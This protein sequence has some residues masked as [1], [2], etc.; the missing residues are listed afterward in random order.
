MI[1]ILEIC[2]FN[3]QS[4]L[5]AQA[6]GANR[7]EL[8]VDP[9]SGGT[10][11]NM[12]LIKTARQKLDIPLF[13]IIRPRSGDF[14]YSPD[15][16]ESM[17]TDVM[18]CKQLGCDGIVTGMLAPD[19]SID[20]IRS[21]KLVELAYPMEVTFHRAFDWSLNPHQSL[22]DILQIGCERILTSGQQTSAL[23]GSPLIGEL[24]RQADDRIVVM[25]G[26]GIRSSNIV[27]IAEKTGATE[28][29]S[30][31]RSFQ[32]SMMIFTQT[33]MQGDQNLIL[34]SSSEIQAMRKGLDQYFSSLQSIC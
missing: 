20:K 14:L 34:A 6:F 27:E 15:E 30:S 25:P 19:G 16:F 33:S 12:G 22:E 17:Q 24:I 7:I 1:P 31:A 32:N 26:A 23:A 21:A 8:C 28:F 29:H 10:T 3:L 5:V 4:A 9:D 11:P 18:L 2:C 13:P